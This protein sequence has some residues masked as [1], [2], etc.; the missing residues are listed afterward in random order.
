MLKPKKRGLLVSAIL[1]SLLF[2]AGCSHKE[3][4]DGMDNVPFPGKEAG[5]LKKEYFLHEPPEEKPPELAVSEPRV[6]YSIRKFSPSEFILHEWTKIE[7]EIICQERKEIF[8][9]HFNS[10]F[11]KDITLDFNSTGLNMIGRFSNETINDKEVAAY[12]RN[13]GI[14]TNPL[15]KYYITKPEEKGLVMGYSCVNTKLIKDSIN[16]MSSAYYDFL[17][18]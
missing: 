17:N 13:K 16:R 2:N 18:L 14:I 4:R 1:F 12:L 6:L 9:N 15:S 7:K 8:I 11:K 3:T 10:N 5:D